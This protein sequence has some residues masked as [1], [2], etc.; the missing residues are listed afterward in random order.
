MTGKDTKPAG[1]RK[2]PAGASR[3][4][5]FGAPEPKP[6]RKVALD[7]VLRSLQD[8]VSNELAVEP[9]P[10]AAPEKTANIPAV[11]TEAPA[12]VEPPTPAAADSM[13][14]DFSPAT[15]AAPANDPEP[16][17]LTRARRRETRN[18]P[19]PLDA[20]RHGHD[21]S[22]S[23]A[24][25]STESHSV[26]P[27]AAIPPG[28]LQQELPHLEPDPVHT[29]SALP[30]APAQ[31]LEPIITELPELEIL[32]PT[33]AEPRPATAAAAPD[34]EHNHTPTDIPVLDDVVEEIEE[35]EAIALPVESDETTPFIASALPQGMDARKLA[36]QIAARLNVELRKDG[37]PVLSSDVIARLAH[38][39]EEALAK[40]AANMDNNAQK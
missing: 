13:T 8:L 4:R 25:A 14:I 30:A 6:S 31:N 1:S 10:R 15:E 22:P 21:D 20:R 19:N 27:A 35:V 32:P 23:T 5:D 16:Q 17:V 3:P 34:H 12:P 39:L 11:A 26:T 36:I 28:G 33:D 18:P 37:K 24:T 2:L 40:A 29:P 7:E 38:A 9:A